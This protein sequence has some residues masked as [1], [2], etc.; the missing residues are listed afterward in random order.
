[1]SAPSPVNPIDPSMKIPVEISGEVRRLLHDL[2]NALEI[3]VQAGYLLTTTDTEP[4]VKEW[5]G[6][7]DGGAQQ[8]MTVHRELREFIRLHS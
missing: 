5:I 7:L 4:P 6:L 8:A 3:V 2:S 1:M